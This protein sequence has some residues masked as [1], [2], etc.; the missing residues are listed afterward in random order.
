MRDRHT[1]AHADRVSHLDSHVKAKVCGA[2][3]A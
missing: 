1:Q 2:S 3:R